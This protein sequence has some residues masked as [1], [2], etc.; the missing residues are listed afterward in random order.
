MSPHSESKNHTS[1]FEVLPTISLRRFSPP[2]TAKIW[3]VKQNGRF[4]EPA[5]ATVGVDSGAPKTL[6]RNIA[7][8]TD[9][10][11]ETAFP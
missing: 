2:K 1:N 5:S 10:I 11:R 9:I 3:T 8:S 4:S 6:A 7:K